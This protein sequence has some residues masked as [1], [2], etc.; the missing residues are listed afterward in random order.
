MRAVQSVQGTLQQL[1]DCQNDTTFQLSKIAKIHI[2]SVVSYFTAELPKEMCSNRGFRG[3]WGS[4][5]ARL[6][7]N[8]MNEAE[9][10]SNSSIFTHPKFRPTK[11][12]SPKGSSLRYNE[13]ATFWYFHSGYATEPQYLV[14]PHNF[15]IC[16]PW[17]FWPLM[18]I[19]KCLPVLMFLKSTWNVVA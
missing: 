3:E 13:Q 4:P 2:Q 1:R 17:K 19:I 11:L 6:F 12:F 9:Q 14:V 10:L 8:P 18:K 15:Y 7:Q 5:N 16:D